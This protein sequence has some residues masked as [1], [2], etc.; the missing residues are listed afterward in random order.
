[1]DPALEPN[2]LAINPGLVMVLVLARPKGSPCGHCFDGVVTVVSR[3]G[4]LLYIYC[5]VNASP[6][7][8][9]SQTTGPGRF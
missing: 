8:A 4:F 5:G 6:Q 7:W 2:Q 3:G 1:M 9:F